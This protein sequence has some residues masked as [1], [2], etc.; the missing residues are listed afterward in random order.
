METSNALSCPFKC[1]PSVIHRYNTSHVSSW[2]IWNIKIHLSGWD[3]LNFVKKLLY[4]ELMEVVS[5]M[6]N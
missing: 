6:N 4:L 1:T 5:A 3:L 2:Q